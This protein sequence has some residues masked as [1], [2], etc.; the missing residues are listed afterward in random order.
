MKNSKAKQAQHS[1][2]KQAVADIFGIEKALIYKGI[3]T[4]TAAQAR[5]MFVG[6]L[7]YNSK[8]SLTEIGDSLGYAQDTTT[9]QIM[10]DH[11]KY[12]DS[13]KEY[14]AKYEQLTAKLKIG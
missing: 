3:T 6:Y 7:I 10:K 8:D 4:G 5:S 1:K 14:K 9:F 2:V 13:D 12:M 11:V